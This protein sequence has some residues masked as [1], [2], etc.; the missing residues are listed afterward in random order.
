MT[1]NG[2]YIEI[3]SYDDGLN[4]AS[5]MY[6]KGGYIYVVASGNDA[7]DSNGN[8]Y[9]SGGKIFCYGSEEGFDANTEGG[10]KLYIQSGAC[11]MAVGA[12][13][14]ALENNA[15]LSQ[16]CK[17]ASVSGNTWYALYSGNSVA[18]A[19]YTPTFSGGGGGGWGGGS[20][21]KT[22]VVS[23]PSTPALYKNVTGSGTSLWSGKGY[24]NATGGSSVTLSNYSG[25]SGPGP[26]F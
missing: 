19:A 7:I 2:G 8:M 26:G 22:M 12:T 16:T 15:Q 18:F 25:G 17:Q 23:A 1:I 9:V 3:S 5:T 4:S 11:F 13:M 14:G 6:L 10:A 20:S 21:T 24:T